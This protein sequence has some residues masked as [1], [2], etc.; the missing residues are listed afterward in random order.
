[1][2]PCGRSPWFWLTSG[3]LIV[4]PQTGFYETAENGINAAWF[5]RIRLSRHRFQLRGAAIQARLLLLEVLSLLLNRCQPIALGLQLLL[6]SSTAL[7]YVGQC[8][9]ALG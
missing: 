7:L 4:A 5:V 8:C 2:H 3:R 6:L 1:M 9:F